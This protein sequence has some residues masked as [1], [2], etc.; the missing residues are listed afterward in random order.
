MGEDF[1]LFVGLV[2][3]VFGTALGFAQIYF[4][5]RGDKRSLLLHRPLSSGRIFIAKSIAGVALY[6]LGIGIPFVCIVCLAATPGHMPQPFVWAS[7][8][9]W[10][11]DILVGVVFY[12][13][14]MLSGQWEGRW[15][16]SRCLP[17]G[18]GLCCWF[19]AWC[20]PEF[21]QAVMAAVITGSIVALAAWGSFHRGGLYESQPVLT[22]LAVSLVFLM[23]LSV[24][25]FTGKVFVAACFLPKIDSYVR[26]D[27]QGNALLAQEKNGSLTLTGLNGEAP[28]G[29]R[30]RE[31]DAHA[32]AEIAAPWGKGPLPT[33]R[34]YRSTS[35]AFLKYA[36]E[37][38]PS[39]EWW[40]YVPKY[41]R[42][43]GFDRKSYQPIGS[44]GPAGFAA[45]GKQATDRFMEPLIYSSRV[46]SSSVGNYLV[47]PRGVYKV[48]FRERQVH[49][50]FSPSGEE[51]VQWTT[52]WED[53][54]L[55]LAFVLTN[56]AIHV[57]DE[58]GKRFASLPAPVGFE[59]Y[60]ASL[61][62]RLEDPTRYWVLYEPKWYLPLET[63]EEM[64]ACLLAFDGNSGKALSRQVIPA[65]PGK[66]HAIKP[67]IPLVDACGAQIGSGIITSAAES[68]ALVGM[69][70]SFVSNV[71]E[72]DGADFPLA[73][74]WLIVTT[75]LFLPGVRW[76]AP[77]HPGVAYGFVGVMLLAALVS[78]VACY[79]MARRHALSR[80]RRMGW[81]LAGFVLGLVGVALM[82]SLQ[83][84]PARVR[85][86]NCGKRRV[87]TRDACEHCGAA[88]ALPN[89]DGT[90]IFEPEDDVAALA[91]C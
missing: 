67:P 17:L 40:W 68:A 36:N 29:A 80:A 79:G 11:A 5:S 1:L 14:G 59:N 72:S 27:R 2:Q 38:Q 10:V 55:T 7:L 22:K 65:R 66:A 13:A 74:Y 23:G 83:D 49:L 41:G 88:H 21:A 26:V 39:Y 31:L 6:L 50:I 34:S 48:D 18:A 4:E 30:N 56:E 44:F 71:K 43:L 52:R 61:L 76:F 87:V 37:T 15:Y 82:I 77:S 86:P 58:T 62:G 9:P 12:F 70:N 19:I 85:C 54:K 35:R 84:W 63:L 57:I 64:P 81:T 47:F 89:R 45:P 24:L 91:E 8:L 3:I 78:A 75:Q 25:S 33:M 51:T 53:E 16:G 73:L 60:E 28:A 32:L 69:T 20:A 46:Y 42:L 90:E